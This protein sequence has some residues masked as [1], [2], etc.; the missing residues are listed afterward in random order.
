MI[1]CSG[2]RETKRRTIDAVKQLVSN[3]YDMAKVAAASAAGGTGQPVTAPLAGNIF[4][5]Q[6]TAGQQIRE[7]DVIIILE[8]MKMETEVR[9]TS[10]GAVQ[11]VLVKEG[12][13]VAV[14]DQLITIA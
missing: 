6:V 14:G 4:K 12:D 11:S 2:L 9:A 8:A 10:S 1:V 7:G 3:I 13:S 5:V